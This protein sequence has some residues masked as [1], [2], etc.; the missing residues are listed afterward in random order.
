MLTY[1]FFSKMSKI[2]PD[3]VLD[4]WVKKFFSLYCLVDDHV[5]KGTFWRGKEIFLVWS[6]LGKVKKFFWVWSVLGK[7]KISRFFVKALRARYARFARFAPRPAFGRP[8]RAL[9]WE[10]HFRI[11]IWVHNSIDFHLKHYKISQQFVH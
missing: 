9:R 1:S 5:T 7:V 6:V 4:F 3:V 8:W 10:N 2:C 11:F